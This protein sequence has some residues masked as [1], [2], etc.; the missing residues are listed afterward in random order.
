MLVFKRIGGA[1]ATPHIEPEQFVAVRDRVA[2]PHEADQADQ[3]EY[4]QSMVDGQQT[5]VV[6]D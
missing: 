3:A 2:D 1:H 5:G 6:R 4:D